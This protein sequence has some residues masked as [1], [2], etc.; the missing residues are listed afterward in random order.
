[1]HI[2]KTLVEA[3][4]EGIDRNTQEYALIKTLRKSKAFK[5]IAKAFRFRQLRKFANVICKLRVPT[6]VHARITKSTFHKY[7]AKAASNR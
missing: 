2:V 1:M 3:Q 7:L 4:L 6:L 5:N